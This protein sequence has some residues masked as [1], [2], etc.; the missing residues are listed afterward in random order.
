MTGLA[1]FLA[2]RIAEDE[3]IAN[4][5]YFAARIPEQIPDFY[6]AGGP[7]AEQFWKRFDTARA[8]REAEA[9]RAI[10][11]EHTTDGNEDHDDDYVNGDCPTLLALAAVY[12]GH[13][14][15][16]PAWEA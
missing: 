3:E 12:R 6:A 15:F 7:A 13:A 2:A 8:L 10:L 11:A 1:G 16:D 5:L 9:K 4:S 14:D